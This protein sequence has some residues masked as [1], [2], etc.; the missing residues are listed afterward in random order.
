PRLP[1]ALGHRLVLVLAA[2]R[3]AAPADPQAV[4]APLPAFRRLPVAGRLRSPPRA[5]RRP[6]RQARAPA[7]GGG[8]PGRRDPGGSRCRVPALLRRPAR[9]APPLALPLAPPY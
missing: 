2:V 1:L 5:V 3:R 8:D 9:T 4:A 7:A 6:Q